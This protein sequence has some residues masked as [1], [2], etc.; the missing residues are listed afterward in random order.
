M[1][2]QTY[3]VCFCCRRRFRLASAEAPAE[4]KS[5]FA[6]YSENGTISVDNLH[7]FLVEVQKQENATVEDAEAILNSLHEP[8]HL[9]I[10]HR[11][12]LNLEQFFKYLFGDINPPIDPRRG[13]IPFLLHL[14]Q[15]LSI[16]VDFF[17]K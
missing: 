15:F 16:R 12:G 10:F 13:V 14:Y 3:R 11:S 1:S 4:I 7:R 6:S 9:N 5:L 8:K 17:F 2:K